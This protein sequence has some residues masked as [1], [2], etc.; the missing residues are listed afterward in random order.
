M[1][2]IA[3]DGSEWSVSCIGYFIPRKRAPGTNLIRT[4][5]DMM[6]KRKISLLL[7]IEPQSSCSYSSHYTNCAVMVPFLM[8]FVTCYKTSGKH[9]IKKIIFLCITGAVAWNFLSIYSELS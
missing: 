4:N 2:V 3:V 6:P 9:T 1:F 7:G 5:L 8:H